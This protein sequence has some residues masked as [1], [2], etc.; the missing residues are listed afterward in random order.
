M[1][2]LAVVDFVSKTFA[3]RPVFRLNNFSVKVNQTLDGAFLTSS[4]KS[5]RMMYKIRI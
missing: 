2:S 5:G 3:S 1:P 4:V